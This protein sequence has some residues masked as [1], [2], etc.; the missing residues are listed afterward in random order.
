MKSR[1]VA[2]LVSAA[3]ALYV[4]CVAAVFCLRAVLPRLPVRQGAPAPRGATTPR[5]PPQPG[6]PPLAP[7]AGA[8]NRFD[9]TGVAAA[10]G[11]ALYP[12]AA[13][14]GGGWSM[15]GSGAGPRAEGHLHF[16]VRGRPAEVVG[17][18][19]ERYASR[20]PVVLTRRACGAAQALVHWGDERGGCAVLVGSSG[21]LPL[22]PLQLV[23]VDLDRDSP[24]GQTTRDWASAVP[25]SHSACSLPLYPGA[26]VLSCVSTPGRYGPVTRACLSADAPSSTV[27]R[28]Y[29]DLKSRYARAGGGR[30]S[31][32]GHLVQMTASWDDGDSHCVASLISPSSQFPA[33]VWLQR[34]EGEAWDAVR[35]RTFAQARRQARTPREVTR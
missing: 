4:V 5:L 14:G 1:R 20:H 26:G 31:S 28:Y 2:L 17:F 13:G 25:V 3:V 16:T 7:G 24:A 19:R 29:E 35:G 12:G 9:T 34:A 8:W 27:A 18:Y 22:T 11:I 15:S 23:R 30:S 32:N 21:L 33:I 10:M 6:G